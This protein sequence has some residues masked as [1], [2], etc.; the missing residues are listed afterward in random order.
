MRPRLPRSLAPAGLGAT[1]ALLAMA[2]SACGS[3]GSSSSRAQ[4]TPTTGTSQATTTPTTGAPASTAPRRPRTTPSGAPSGA[5]TGGTPG[6]GGGGAT[7]ASGPAAAIAIVARQGYAVHDSSTYRGDQTLRVLVGTTGRK[8]TGRLQRAFFFVGDRYI[9]TDASTPSAGVSVAGQD[10]TSV[11]L[12]YR[13]FRPTDP[14]CCPTG[15]RRSV[16]F[17]LD[18]GKLA[19]DRA[20]PPA[21]PRA[22]LSRR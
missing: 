6:P 8:M 10:D 22:P 16:R 13:L 4:S 7:A 11:T 19:P 14:L 5:G 9:G 20:I 12:S 2:A 15:G 3:S 17:V 18:N 21:S 1:A